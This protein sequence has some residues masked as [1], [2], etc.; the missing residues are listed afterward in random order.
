MDFPS[1]TRVG[2]GLA[3]THGW[4]IVISPEAK[5]G[6]NVTLFHGVTIGQRDKV[7]ENGSRVTG[8]P[9]IEDDVW[10]GPNAV[11][12]GGVIIGRGS[13]IAAGSFVTGNI[14]PYSVVVGN[15][16][17]IV[18]TGCVPD[19]MNKAPLLHKRDSES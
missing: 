11:I 1:R 2:A 5:I 3:I 17:I 4:G 18:K 10:I 13:K 16:G 9:V 14:P 7:L 12:V 15:P 8:Y 19:V 6:E